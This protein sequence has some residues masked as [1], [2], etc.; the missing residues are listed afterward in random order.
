MIVSRAVAMAW[1]SSSPCPAPGARRRRPHGDL[2]DCRPAYPPASVSLPPTPASAARAPR[3]GAIAWSLLCL[4]L[5]ASAPFLLA[6]KSA[7]V[8]TFHAECL[9][10]LL[11]L[12]ALL[13]LAGRGG[14][15]ALPRVL[16]LPLGLAGLVVLQWGLGHLPFLQ[17]A[18]LGCLYLLWAAA[19]MLLGAHLRRE[20]GLARPAAALAWGLAAGAL[21]SALVGWG[22]H[23]GSPLL[24]EPWAMPPSPLRVWANLGQPNHLADYLALGVASLAF[25][26]QAGRLRLVLALPAAAALAYVMALTGSRAGGLY[27]GGMTLLALALWRWLPPQLRSRGLLVQAVALLAYL[28]LASGAVADP[29]RHADGPGAAA[30]I[31]RFAPEAMQAEERPRL[32]RAAWEIFRQAP[33]LGVGFRNFGYHYFLLNP[34]LPAPRVLGFNDHCHNLALNLLAEFGLAGGILLVACLLPWLRALRSLARDPAGLW[35][36][37]ALLVLGVHSTVEYPLWYAFFL[38]PAALLLG[39][40]DASLLQSG[41]GRPGVMRWAPAVMLLLGGVA[42]GQLFQD[43]RRLE[44]F[45]ALRYGFMDVSAES[46]AQARTLMLET[47]RGSLLAPM[48]VL[49]L[50]RSVEISRDGLADKLAVNGRAQRLFPVDDVS[51]RQ[52]MLLAL[53]GR[54]AEATA[55]WLR[56]CASYPAE[57]ARALRVLDQGAEREPRLAHFRAVRPAC[58]GGAPSGQ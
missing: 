9:A 23:I 30:T 49:G 4:A 45:L 11:G 5:M 42:L 38:G 8:P 24:H 19:L 31:E 52:A 27:L 34:S 54:E 50:A 39:L 16:L 33:L 22:Q 32:W 47:H 46:A 55:E 21:A 28:V 13:P 43:Y 44:N 40:G 3:P 29:A 14:S 57:E 53:D 1:H 6:V 25:L 12:L 36:L 20:A 2:I 37:S 35:L 17:Q 7:P 26:A 15:L 18:L 51:Y 48:A 56:G 41:P 58:A 10:A